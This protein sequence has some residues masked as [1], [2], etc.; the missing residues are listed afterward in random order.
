MD[1]KINV[2]CIPF[3]GG[4]KY[5][6]AGLKKVP[7]QKTT[8]IPIEIPG[9][10]SRYKELLLT[11]MAQIADDLLAQLINKIDN[12]YAIYGHSMGALLAYLLTKRLLQENLSLP[13]RLF[14]SGSGGP[15]VKNRITSSYL[16]PKD[17]FL[18]GIRKLGGSMEQAIN[19]PSIMN[20]YEP[21]LR[22]DFQ[23]VE[24]YKYQQ[25]EPFAI[26]V[27]V[28]FGENDPKVTFLEASAWQKETQAAIEIIPFP[29]SH[30]F[31]FGQESRIVELI[32]ERLNYPVPTCSDLTCL[33]G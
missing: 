32:E 16:L 11:D 3:A 29:G 21:I 31:I 8:F 5:S 26:P 25:E 18:E 23:A 15:S 33:R 4:S 30:F 19:D 17:A 22:A 20:I 13:I 14:V 7:A 2:F 24:L 28:F 10:G 6:F 27:T 9:R 12:P 1:K